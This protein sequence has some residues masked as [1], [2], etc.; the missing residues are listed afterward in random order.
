M[1]INKIVFFLFANNDEE[2]SALFTYAII[3]VF[4]GLE[5]KIIKFRQV[6]LTHGH[7]RLNRSGNLGTSLK[8]YVNL[9]TYP[10]QI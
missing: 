6:L 3:F 4:F 2:I 8:F 5:F 1:K 9:E 7:E 10:N